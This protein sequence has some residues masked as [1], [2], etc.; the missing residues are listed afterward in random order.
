M[1]FPAC[2]LDTVLF[3]VAR[4]GLRDPSKKPDRENRCF[5][6]ELAEPFGQ[7]RH[8]VEQVVDDAVIGDVD[9]LFDVVP[10]LTEQFS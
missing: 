8:D 2:E 4:C 3:G 7:C 6:S 1:T 10:A 9:D 5:A